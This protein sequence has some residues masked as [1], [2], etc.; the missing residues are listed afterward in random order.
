[1]HSYVID[2]VGQ[3]GYHGYGTRSVQSH[4]IEHLH[5]YLRIL[6]LKAVSQR[7][8]GLVGILLH[9]PCKLLYILTCD[10]REFLRVELHLG[11]HVTE[12]R[13]RHLVTK[14]VLVHHGTES[15]ELSLRDAELLGKPRSPGGEVNK[16]SGLGT[17]VLSQ[18]I[19]GRSCGQHGIP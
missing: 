7:Q 12:G 3:C 10:S 18:L 1:M 15:H 5:H 17:G 16:E 19:D 14:K 13:G 9:H 11:E 4:V 2:L 6:L 8:H